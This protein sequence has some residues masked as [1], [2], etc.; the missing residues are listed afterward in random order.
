MRSAE[1]PQPRIESR[2]GKLQ[3]TAGLFYLLFLAVLL[4]GLLQ[5]AGY[6]STALYLEDALA[7]SNLASA[8]LDIREYGISHT[9]RISDPAGAY[10]LYLA[11]LR[12][13]LNLDEAWECPNKSLISGPVTVE[14]YIV[15]NVKGGL[16]TA[17]RVGTDGQWTRETNPVG[18]VCSPDGIPIE[19]TGIYSEI[20]FPVEGFLGL[21]V[22]AHKGKLADI[23]V[24]D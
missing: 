14:A 4:C 11:A 19:A 10:E 7:A 1:R 22:T 16:V 8:V 3:W 9:V 17:S 23:V 6:R 15:Y 24:N 21:T 13:N 5:E 12:E 18:S 2:E 20:S